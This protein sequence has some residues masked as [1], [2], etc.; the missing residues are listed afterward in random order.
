MAGSLTDR[1]I[2]VTGAASGMGEAAA[3]EL[4]ASGAS[5]ALWDINLPAASALAARL[6]DQG[7]RCLALG[8]DV[9][10]DAEVAVHNCDYRHCHVQHFHCGGC[11]ADLGGC[12]SAGTARNGAACGNTQHATYNR[13]HATCDI[14]QATYNTQHATF[15]I[16]HPASN[17]PN[18]RRGT[19]TYGMHAACTGAAGWG[20]GREGGCLA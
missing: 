8:V 11:A 6:Q 16:Q 10:R 17:F 12:C 4:A 5:L 18:A 3:L 13:Q 2:V 9:S 1:H 7:S 20:V 19:R 15:S 14:Q